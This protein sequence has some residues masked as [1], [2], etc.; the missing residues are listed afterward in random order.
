MPIVKVHNAIVQEEKKNFCSTLQ[1]IT[2]WI[3][4]I[5][6]RLSYIRSFSLNELECLY[7][8]K[9]SIEAFW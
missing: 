7:V 1:K 4:Y 2:V 5:P 9:E 3:E 8:L 6:N